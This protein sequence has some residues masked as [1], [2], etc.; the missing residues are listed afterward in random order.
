MPSPAS[1]LQ[2]SPDWAMRMGL[3]EAI[4][5]QFLE[6]AQLIL[7][8][9]PLT[10][11]ENQ[12]LTRFPFWQPRD[13][14]RISKSLSDQ[15]FLTIHSAPLSQSLELSVSFSKTSEPV[16]QLVKAKSQPQEQAKPQGGANHISPRWQ[17]DQAILNRLYQDHGIIEAFAK[18]QV[19]EFVRYWIDSGKV[20]HS[21]AAKFYARVVEKW[22]QQRGEMRFLETNQPKATAMQQGWKPHPDALE[23]LTRNGINKTFIEDAIPEFVLY[24]RERGT[25][26]ET[27]NSHFIKHVKRQWTIFTGTAKYDTTPKPIPTDWQ[28]APE[29]F[30]ILQ[31]AHIDAQFAQNCIKEFILY[32]QESGRLQSSWN[33]KFLQHVKYLWANQH[34]LQGTA[35]AK[36]QRPAGS[37]NLQPASYLDKHTDRSWTEGL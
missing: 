37:G 11:S 14:Q 9:S 12:L 10:L 1:T 13:I 25:A 2:F 6:E 7:Q 18:Q 19:S 36:E 24:W 35:Y 28:P 22:Q 23:I 27:W 34:L 16:V 15:G 20:S 4:L 30:D 32:W 26:T 3:E 8:R 29:V 31:L 5:W 17:P 33:T 21:W